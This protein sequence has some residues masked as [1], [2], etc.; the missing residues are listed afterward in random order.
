L[1]EQL[2]GAREDYGSRGA[3]GCHRDTVNET[4][5]ISLSR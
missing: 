2:A 3:I 4:N 5:S 1:R